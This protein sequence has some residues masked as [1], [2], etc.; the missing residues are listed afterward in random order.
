MNSDRTELN[1]IV[2]E[3]QSQLQPL[4]FVHNE[5]EKIIVH[6]VKH[7]KMA[8]LGSVVSVWDNFHM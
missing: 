1:I 5:L 8:L 2:V 7:P 6:S 4:R 3:V